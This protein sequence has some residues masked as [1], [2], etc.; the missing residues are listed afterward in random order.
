MIQSSKSDRVIENGERFK[1]WKGL[2][3]RIVFLLV[4]LFFPIV[5]LAQIP[6]NA[7]RI[8]TAEQLRAIGGELSEGKYFILTNDIDLTGEWSQISNFRGTFDGQGHS[9]NNVSIN[10]NGKNTLGLFGHISANNVTI[11]NVKVNVNFYRAASLGASGMQGNQNYAGG[12]IAYSTSSITIE[13]CHVAGEI[14]ASY[15]YS[16]GSG[17]FSGGL[18]GYCRGE[19]LIKNSRVE[20]NVS[21]SSSSGRAHAGGLVGCAAGIL[22]IENSHATGKVSS[23]YAGGILGSCNKQATIKNCYSTGDVSASMNGHA[24]GIIGLCEGEGTIIESCHT[25]GNISGSPSNRPGL[26]NIYTYSGHAGGLIGNCKVAV[27][28]K[29]SYT[30]GNIIAYQRDGGSSFVGGLIGACSGWVSIE[31]SYATGKKTAFSLILT[32]KGGVE[33]GGVAGGLIVPYSMNLD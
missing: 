31:N 4:I 23:D 11:K 20:A 7:V 8:S 15:P 2:T 29:N 17:I 1:N 10:M 32:G 28:I 18:I 14:T 9:I 27:T 16:G 24:G 3:N 30:T 26:S 12:L 33:I 22:T 19:A 5:L 25:S 13:N 21:A 6:S